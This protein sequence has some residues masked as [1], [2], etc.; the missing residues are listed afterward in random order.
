MGKHKQRWG[1]CFDCGMV[2]CMLYDEMLR[3]DYK[4]KNTWSNGKFNL[5]VP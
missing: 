1:S 4:V 2:T 3:T 5:L